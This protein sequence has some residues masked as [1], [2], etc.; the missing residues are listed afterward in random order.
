[1]DLGRMG[2]PFS[3]CR[4][5]FV[6]ICYNREYPPHV[7]LNTFPIISLSRR[8]GLQTVYSGDRAA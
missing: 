2:R 6:K 1:M 3:Y 4:D 5:N 7:S 8:I